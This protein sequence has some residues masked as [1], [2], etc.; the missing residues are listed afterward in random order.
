MSDV[1]D[2]ITTTTTSTTT[3]TTII[4][5]TVM[6]ATAAATTTTAFSSITDRTDIWPDITDGTSTGSYATYTAATTLMTATA[7]ATTATAPSSITDRAD[8]WPD[9]TDGTSTASSTTN[10]AGAP[11]TMTVLEY[12]TTVAIFTQSPPTVTANTQSDVT[13]ETTRQDD[14]A[15]ISTSMTDMSI[16]VFQSS[17]VAQTS[18][19]TTSSSTPS[20]TTGV[21]ISPVVGTT[22]LRS[23][24]VETGDS[25]DI[26]TPTPQ[27]TSTLQTT[28]GGRYTI[29]TSLTD[30]GTDIDSYVSISDPVTKPSDTTFPPDST[31]STISETDNTDKISNT[32]LSADATATPTGTTTVE[33]IPEITTSDDRAKTGE[34]P[35]TLLAPTY[36]P[37]NS[38]FTAGTDANFPDVPTDTAVNKPTPNVLPPDIPG[39]GESPPEVPMEVPIPTM[40][41]PDIAL[42]DVPVELPSPDLSLPDQAAPEGLVPDERS[43]DTP[44]SNVPS[45]SGQAPSDV[46][47]SAVPS[48]DV[49]P[50]YTL[51]PKVLSNGPRPDE[52][53]PDVLPS[54]VSPVDVFTLS[55]PDVP[56]PETQVPDLPFPNEL[57]PPVPS[58]EPPEPTPKIQ[59]P[60]TPSPNVPLPD[61]SS[62]TSTTRTLD[63][64]IDK[65]PPNGI[66]PDAAAESELPFPKQEGKAAPA[67]NL[68]SPDLSGELAP[69]DFSFPFAEKPSSVE[70]GSDSSLLPV[71]G[72]ANIPST[73]PEPGDTVQSSIDIS[74]LDSN[75][76]QQKSGTQGSP[77]PDS[78]GVDSKPD[79]P[80][81]VGNQQE[82]ISKTQTPEES[83]G[84]DSTSKGPSKEPDMDA[85]TGNQQENKE[86]QQT[87]TL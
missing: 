47:L 33:T 45:P 24:A 56:L 7:A 3:A 12:V 5:T 59:S 11:T 2:V 6:T 13:A 14:I 62:E 28:T 36:Q 23:L 70:S 55:V 18:D 10:S 4:A 69:V 76:T 84:E 25:L 29:Y 77:K 81:D 38:S 39:S 53:P 35:S 82:D 19:V 43:L 32:T 17:T 8:T 54:D 58:P 46:G 83:T 49:P 78:K 30:V 15:L 85:K 86:S 68:E 87:G 42:P 66:P 63:T 52:A 74:T 1:S 22:S 72:P 60:D 80:E 73:S 41:P 65:P 57:P 71:G 48:P 67:T 79:P 37:G 34:G 50:S 27:D 26:A 21:S 51:L 20:R 61:V 64:L 16:P 40:L 44:S 9:I 31:D 75:L